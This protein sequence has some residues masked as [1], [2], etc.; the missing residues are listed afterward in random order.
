MRSSSTNQRLRSR[1]NRQPT[2]PANHRSRIVFEPKL[3]YVNS[4]RTADGMLI[5]S[6]RKRA[7]PTEAEKELKKQRKIAVK[8]K[9]VSLVALRHT[10]IA[11]YEHGI[12]LPNFQFGPKETAK[13]VTYL[14]TT[15]PQYANKAAAK[16]F[17]YRVIKRHNSAQQTPHLDPFRDRRGENRTCPKRKNA[18]IV[19]LCDE[20][21]SEPKATAP[22]ISRQLLRR[23]HTV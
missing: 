8:V 6:K 1:R 11:I 21:L 7:P 4:S 23:G 19:M 15:N 10:I 22:K 20:L 2:T 12:H 5:L 13:I 16:S 9:Q 17:V 14:Q 3:K 18:E